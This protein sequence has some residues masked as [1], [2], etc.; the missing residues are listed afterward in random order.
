MNK[1]IIL[2]AG[3]LLFTTATS[4]AQFSEF[5]GN[6]A[7]SAFTLSS[8]QNTF[9]IGGRV[10]FYYEKRFMKTGY[11]NLN[12]DGFAV[13]DLD[14]DFL[15]KTANKFTY[16]LHLSPIDW[17]AAAA[18]QNTANPMNSGIKEAYIQ[19]DKYRVK[20]KL[21]Y[22]KIPFSQGSLTD[23]Y[24]SPLW[25][26]ANLYGGDFFS[27]R[28]IGLTLTASALHKQLRMYG[29][30]YSGLGENCFEYGNDAS[31][32]PEFAGRVEYSFPGR[33]K[34][35]LIDEESRPSPTFRIGVNG[36]YCDKTQPVG[37]T[38][39]SDV[40]DALG[41]YNL[42]IVGGKKSVYGADF[43]AMYKGFSWLF[44]TDMVQ[45]KPTDA[46]DAVY[47][48]TLSSQN[49]NVVNAGGFATNLNYNWEKMHSTFSVMYEN[50]NANDMVIGHQEWLYLAYAYKLSGFNSVLKAEYYLPSVEDKI[51][52]PLKYSGQLRIGYQIVF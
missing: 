52:N 15:G 21:G 7:A 18:T 40:P 42:R 3:V 34:Y 11:T 51:S 45:L 31:G 14:L 8:D 24:G 2:A 27:R 26:H 1:N 35:Q 29:G 47:A 48:G 43:I 19:F 46:T 39:L 13:K 50:L 49:G 9:Q 28:D 23:V 10:S 17:V 16:E 33:I 6:Q 38:I 36:R 37:H 32:K 25:S 20:I 5:D 22:D 30:I 12:H 4:W 41:P 44:E